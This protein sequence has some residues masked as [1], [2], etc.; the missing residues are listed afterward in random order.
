MQAI[1][2]FSMLSARFLQHPRCFGVGLHGMHRANTV[3]VFRYNVAWHLC[4][5][6][7]PCL[8][9]LLCA[10]LLCSQFD[11]TLSGA[12]APVSL[13]LSF[14]GQIGQNKEFT[15]S[16]PSWVFDGGTSPK[17]D[18]CRK[19]SSA[20]PGLSC[21]FPVLFLVLACALQRSCAPERFH[22]PFSLARVTLDV[23]TPRRRSLCP[24][25]VAS[26]SLSYPRHPFNL[27]AWKRLAGSPPNSCVQRRPGQPR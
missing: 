24:D 7:L 15:P 14:R 20:T 18:F 1:T 17:H 2:F 5:S 9:S 22:P 19:V 27:P 21:A 23:A 26:S 3:P 11:A 25:A 16:A 10:P 13:C 4:A 12:Q 8:S 6:T